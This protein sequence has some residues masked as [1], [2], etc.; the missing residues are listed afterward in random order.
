MINTT[1]VKTAG[2][3]STGAWASAYVGNVAITANS[4]EA[5]GMNSAGIYAS[6]GSGDTSVQVGSVTADG[7]GSV[8]ILAISTG[9]TTVNVDSVETAG[10]G[11]Q[12]IGTATYIT[13]GT[14]S[15]SGDNADGIYVHSNVFNSTGYNYPDMNITAGSVTTGGDYSRGIYAHDSSPDG[16]IGIHVDNVSTDGLFSHGIVAIGENVVG[17]DAGTVETGGESSVG[18]AAIS[19]GGGASIT[20]GSVTT[21]GDGSLG[22]YAFANGPI[23]ISA[24]TVQTGGDYASGVVAIGDGGDIVIKTGD[25]S[26]AGDG[27]YG[28]Y[29]KN[30]SAGLTSISAG[31]VTTAGDNAIGVLGTGFGDIA[32]DT[33]TVS[34]EGGLSSGVIASSVYG[35]V[36]VHAGTVHTGGSYSYGVIAQTS[37]ANSTL[38]VDVGSVNTTGD[39]GLGV[40]AQAGGA[41]EL[42][43]GDVTTSGINAVGVAALF[44]G[45]NG[46]R[47][48]DPV[49]AVIT[50]GSVTTTGAGAGGVDVSG[51]GDV[52]LTVDTVTTSGDVIFYG[53]H[54]NFATG[55]S[56]STAYGDAEATVNAITT[57]GTGAAGFTLATSLGNGTV[58]IGSIE[59]SGEHAGGLSSVA[60]YGDTHLAANVIETSGNYSNGVNSYAF[61]MKDDGSG[62][63][64]DIDIGSVSTRGNYSIGI[65]A[66]ALGDLTIAADAV[67]TAGHYASGIDAVAGG[68]VDITVGKLETAGASSTGVR[69]RSYYADVAI[70]NTDTIATH[71]DYSPGIDA[72]SYAGSVTVTG[73]GAVSTSGQYSTAVSA[74]A[75]NDV[76]I[77]QGD[78]STRGDGSDGIFALAVAG[79]ADVKA[80]SIATEGAGS[81]GATVFSYYGQAGLTADSI[82]TKGYAATGALVVSATGT[83]VDIGTIETSGDYATG[84][85]SLSGYSTDANGYY[86]AGDNTVTLGSV[87]THGTAAI[88]AAVHANVGMVN[89]TAGSISTDGEGSTGL[90]ALSHDGSVTVDVG[91]VTTNGDASFGLALG[92]NGGDVNASVGDVVTHGTGSIGVYAGSGFGNVAIDAGNITTTGDSASAIRLET[93][94][95]DSHVTIDGVVQTGGDKSWAVFTT[96]AFGSDV[97]IDN[98]GKI[99]TAGYDS[100]GINSNVLDGHATI[101]GGTIATTGDNSAG[102]QVFAVGN[103]KAITVTADHI[104]TSGVRAHGINVQNPDDGVIEFRIGATGAKAAAAGD[105]DIA[106]AAK[107]VEVSG[108][109][110]IGI[111]AIGVANVGVDAGTITSAHADAIELKA[112]EMATLTV[113]GMVSGGANG[114]S[115]TGAD[116]NVVIGPK[117][118]ITG[119]VDGLFVSAVGPYVAPPEDDTG[120]GG[121]VGGGIGGGIGTFAVAT[122]GTVTLANG[123]A[124]SGGTGYAVRLGQGTAAIANSGVIEGAVLLGDGDDEFVNSGT[125]TVT[126]D[127]DFGNGNDLFVNTG[128][129]AV[130]PGTTAGAISLLGLERFENQG[131][132]VDLRNGVAGD[133]LTLPGDYVGSD[134]ARIGLDVGAGGKTDTLIVN[135]AATG[136]TGIVLNATAADATLLAQPVTLVKAGAGTAQDAFTLVNQD[137]GFVA[138]GLT[139]DASQNAFGLT[140]RAGNSVRRLSQVTQ[141]AQAIWR[142]QADGWSSHMA[143]LRDAAGN[144]NRVWGQISGKVDTRHGHEDGADLGY[145][146]DYFGL[147]T[148]VDLGGQRDED[149]G[150]GF[151]FGLTGGY[152]S[153]H[154]NLRAGSERLRYQTV[155][156]GAYAS[157]Q[158]GPVFANLLGQ[159][160]H[161]RI[162]AGDKTL[163]WSD[164]FNGNAYGASGEVGTRLGGDRFFAEPTVALSW[165]HTD[166]GTLHALGQAV[167]FGGGDAFDGKVGARLGGVAKLGADATAHFYVRAAYVHRFSGKGTATLDSAG[168]SDAVSGINIG[169]YGQGAIG[170]NIVTA[171]PVSGFIEANGDIGSSYRGAGG[172]AGI[173]L[174]F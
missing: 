78:I 3:Y 106:V 75:A 79:D 89:V 10:R 136:S 131:G 23:Q 135:G 36:T 151:L 173:S 33:D 126:K 166:I 104:T 39:V 88:G 174:K 30:Y 82:T 61:G 168:A 113:S 169:D 139:Y 8:G 114:A 130:R 108:E 155:G 148:G 14:V 144:G 138:Y 81:Y 15:T 57:S 43:T 28:V 170:M 102:I 47:A 132:T 69:A 84:L 17:I 133:T 50:V 164:R 95:G 9:A 86:V 21:H 85:T 160:D 94:Y 162:N 60:F 156:L 73:G 127:S 44:N 98:N 19:Y 35:D 167:D 141:G 59:T 38:T 165:Q 72:L 64:L 4:V 80:G 13:A 27:S 51:R 16:F 99:V 154:L 76:T 110:S 55:V 105:K 153:S 112:R 134:G 146:Q 87:A 129:V 115:V 25:V 54:V 24:D 140:S 147:Q 2:N 77:D 32:I 20:A 26:T 145:R 116:A 70:T 7:E 67:S 6:T 107:A 172:R 143:E 49:G 1:D 45:A 121:G 101:H 142:Q 171:G 65:H 159:Y 124:I 119:A 90:E 149:T 122:G 97:L 91:S 63:A 152:L 123:G 62:Y 93:Q 31:S 66:Q 118:G 48:G 117:G 92:S 42:T 128:L 12:A 53:H 111:R 109:G 46:P 137:V 58:T 41:L 161:Y 56:F 83:K 74:V 37:N 100:A 22:V 96:S 68:G 125:F 158:A 120:T 34:T 157:F 103:T 71:G 163:H 52:T 11:I 5:T 29:A 40:L 150:N 18:I